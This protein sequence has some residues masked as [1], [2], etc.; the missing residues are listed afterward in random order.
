MCG[1]GGTAGSGGERRVPGGGGRPGLARDFSAPTAWSRWAGKTARTPRK[2]PGDSPCRC[3][4][5]ER[6]AQGLASGGHLSGLQTSSGRCLAL[7][8]DPAGVLGPNAGPA[9]AQLRP[10][11]GPA[12]PSA[13]S[14]RLG[15]EPW[16]TD[17]SASLPGRREGQTPVKREALRTVPV[18]MS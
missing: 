2:P 13:R 6:R 4:G 16:G 17:L 10:S 15:N 1:R 14:P 5:E 11:A 3:A 12:A 8:R 7:C 9:P 18:T